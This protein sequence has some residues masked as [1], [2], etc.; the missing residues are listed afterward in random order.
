MDDGIWQSEPLQVML[1]PLGRDAV[2]C[3]SAAAMFIVDPAKSP[4]PDNDLL[5]LFYGLTPA[6]A[7]LA[8]ALA[9]GATVEEYGAMHRLT[10]NTVRTHLKRALSKT[11]THRQ[12]QLV[13]LVANLPG[14]RP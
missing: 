7:R 11:G 9:Q 12:S 10:A 3:G 6:E 2:L 1:Y 13:R 14:A 8:G 5:G 4:V